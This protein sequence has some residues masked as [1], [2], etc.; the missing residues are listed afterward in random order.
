VYW[1]V[2]P[3]TIT[4]RQV[5]ISLAMF[6]AVVVSSGSVSDIKIKDSLVHFGFSWRLIHRLHV[7]QKNP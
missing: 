1:A 6:S 5:R 2:R 4:G 3:F 7:D